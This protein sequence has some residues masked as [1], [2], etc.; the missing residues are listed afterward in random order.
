MGDRGWTDGYSLALYTPLIRSCNEIGI[1]KL[2]I[3][4]VNYNVKEYLRQ[5]LH[6]VG[7]AISGMNAEV[8][9][10]DNASTDGSVE[11][12][13][14]LFPWVKFIVSKENLGFARG[15]NL[16]IH[17]ARGEYVLL[18]NPDTV[19]GEEVLKECVS[20][21]DAHADAGALGVKML[22]ANG[23]FAWES[24]RG[25]PTPFTSFCKMIGLCTLFP[26]SHLMGHY[27]MRYL[28][29]NE[30]ARI[31][32]VSGAFMMLR[33]S[34]LEEIGL[35]DETFFMYG[36][37][38]DLSYRLLKAGYSNYY[39][40]LSIIHYKGES[41]QKTSFRYVQNFY[42]AMLIFYNKHFCG[43]GRRW[44][45]WLIRL[46]IFLRG[47]LEYLLR[48]MAR[49]R[50]L[51]DSDRFRMLVIGSHEMCGEVQSVCHANNMQCL[52]IPLNPHDEEERTLPLKQIAEEK[53]KASYGYIVFDTELFSYSEILAF[54]RREHLR[55]D[56]KRMR[57]GLYSV[58]SKTLVFAS[59]TFS[60]P[61]K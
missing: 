40:P 21:L 53:Q 51:A 47:G 30:P 23:S 35:L 18:L 25:V 38:I 59:S 7:R 4:I 22:K 56:R 55:K 48:Q 10:V 27:Y 42:N 19:V 50:V 39:L 6:S 8:M 1:M 33:R 17:E 41:T 34:A 14:P 20:F 9:V 58:W 43:N 3:V 29:E 49:P 24:R 45:T 16:A 32:I 61:Q 11:E 12:L 54:I 44:L 36:E 13:S 37:D 2:T 28:D 57:L 46:G 52:C 5:C 26:K 31:E 60:L 15:N